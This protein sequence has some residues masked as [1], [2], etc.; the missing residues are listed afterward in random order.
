MFARAGEP[1]AVGRTIDL[2]EPFRAAAHRADLLPDGGTAAPRF[3]RPAQR[4]NHGVH[5]C[6]IRSENR[7]DLIGTRLAL[8]GGVWFDA[9]RLRAITPCLTSRNSSTAHWRT[10]DCRRAN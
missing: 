5:Y 1:G 9:T 7:H 4:A 3:A 6:I 10:S 8:A 2:H